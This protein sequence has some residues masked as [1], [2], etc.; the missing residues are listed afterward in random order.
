MLP[1]ENLVLNI[2][3]LLCIYDH[4][5][6]DIQGLPILLMYFNKPLLK[7]IYS[8]AECSLK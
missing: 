2:L 6:T 4:P 3:V 8:I 1:E 5:C 7:V